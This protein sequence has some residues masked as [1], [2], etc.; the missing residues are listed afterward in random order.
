[1]ANKRKTIGDF[2]SLSS[3][4]M[5][6]MAVIVSL[7][8]VLLLFGYDTISR[9]LYPLVFILYGPSGIWTY[10]IWNYFSSSN[11]PTVLFI[12][13]SVLY[14]FMLAC[15][16]DWARGYLPRKTSKR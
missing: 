11:P 6:I 8:M 1:M 7:Q 14:A 4:K 9:Y 12:L 16:V 2:F 3:D 5:I 15:L 10:G 13:I